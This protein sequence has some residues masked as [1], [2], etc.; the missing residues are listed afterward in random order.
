MLNPF[1][2]NLHVL[3]ILWYIKYD[4]EVE[5]NIQ[6]LNFVEFNILYIKSINNY[7]WLYFCIYQI[8]VYKE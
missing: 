3:F 8:Y 2:F 4:I 7:D 1:F 5:K 6:R